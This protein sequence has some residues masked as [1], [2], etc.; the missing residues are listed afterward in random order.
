MKQHI[1]DSAE[2]LPAL[3][4]R[5]STAGR[6][7]V[8]WALQ[9]LLGKKLSPVTPCLARPNQRS[10]KCRGG[11]GG[12]RLPARR[13]LIE[14]GEGEGASGGAAAAQEQPHSRP[15]RSAEMQRELV[16]QLQQQAQQQQGATGQGA[17]LRR[18]RRRLQ[19]TM[20]S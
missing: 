12:G 19:A 6:L 18:R 7:R 10:I 15:F 2:R 14:M 9:L 20:P 13:S 8:D 5:T 11:R 1:L 17:G 4:G 3:L 16:S